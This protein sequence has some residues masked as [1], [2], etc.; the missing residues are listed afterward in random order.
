MID[1]DSEGE[2]G[3]FLKTARIAKLLSPRDRDHFG[4]PEWQFR[5][6]LK[7]ILVK[8][9]RGLYAPRNVVITERVLL[10][11]RYPRLRL[12]LTSALAA[13]DVISWPAG[14]DW[15]VIGQK[16]HVPATRPADAH[17]VRSSWP[18]DDCDLAPVDDT[19]L[20]AQSPLRALLDCVRFHK[21]LGSD[22]AED[23]MR[24]A[25]AK[26][27]V[28]PDALLSRAKELHVLAPVRSLLARL[29]H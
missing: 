24:A 7:I 25:L 16:A 2:L 22:V 28:T 27:I 14:G 4:V 23:A 18:R 6:W 13:H 10:A 26:G 12:G 9:A 19:Y 20:M 21:R 3:R 11:R 5:M 1:L 17:F 29:H 8:R 15:W